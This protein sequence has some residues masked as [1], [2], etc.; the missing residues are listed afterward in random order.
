MAVRRFTI[1]VPNPSNG[2]ATASLRLEPVPETDLTALGYDLPAERLEIRAVRITSSAPA[3]TLK[4]CLSAVWMTLVTIIYWLL[5]RP[6]PFRSPLNIRLEPRS[7]A[8]VTVSIDAVG[9][10]GAAALHLVDRRGG[11]V[12]G[13]VTLLVL[14]GV[15]E[16]V[17]GPIA[18]PNPCPIVLTEDAF[19]LPAGSEPDAARFAGPVPAGYE[20]DLVA[21]I[22]NPTENVLEGATAYL[23]H[24]GGLD[25][26]FRPAT[27]NLG[28]FEPGATFP[29][30]W[31]I[32]ARRGASGRSIGSIVVA[33]NEF[34]PIRLRTTIEIGS[35]SP[36]EVV[37][38]AEVTPG[39]D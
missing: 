21:R 23:E 24:L 5:R 13:G 4:G 2:A 9:A 33:A 1:N 14:E 39:P 26:E 12:V 27:W 32:S 8:D 28:S 18:A 31:R 36:V 11:R 34:D 6:V 7:A 35:L 37:E 30:R 29:L 16:P 38:V 20:V 17:G 19:W 15:A 22:T 3:S 25:A 10:T